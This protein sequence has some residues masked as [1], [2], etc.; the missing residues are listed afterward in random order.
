M[1]SSFQPQYVFVLASYG[2]C[3]KGPDSLSLC[4]PASM[5]VPFCGAGEVALWKE[6]L[7]GRREMWHLPLTGLEVL[8]GLCRKELT[9]AVFCEFCHPLWSFCSFT[10]FFPEA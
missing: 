2:M 6:H 3:F 5:C 8:L 10:S 4:D 9:L 7:M 1:V